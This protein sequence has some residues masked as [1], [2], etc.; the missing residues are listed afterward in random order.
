MQ[1]RDFVIGRFAREALALAAGA[2][3]TACM[4]SSESQP[5]PG[6]LGQACEPTQAC[7]LMAVPTDSRW[8]SSPEASG[9]MGSPRFEVQADDVHVTCRASLPVP[10][11]TDSRE[12]PPI[13]S[14]ICDPMGVVQIVRERLCPSRQDSDPLGLPDTVTARQTP[15]PGTPASAPVPPPRIPTRH[16]RVPDDPV[17]PQAPP[18]EGGDRRDLEWEASG[19]HRVRPAF[20]ENTAQRPGLSPHL[21]RRARAASPWV[22]SAWMRRWRRATSYT[23][24]NSTTVAS[25][26]K[27]RTLLDTFERRGAVVFEIERGSGLE[28]DGLRTASA[29]AGCVREPRNDA[30]C[31]C[32]CL[33]RTIDVYGLGEV[34]R[35][36]PHNLES[37]PTV[38]YPR[39]PFN[40]VEYITRYSILAG[41]GMMVLLAG[42]SRQCAGGI[43]ARSWGRL[44]RRW[45]EFS[46][47]TE[48]DELGEVDFRS[49]LLAGRQPRLRVQPVLGDFAVTSPSLAPRAGPPPTGSHRSPEASSIVSS[50]TQTS[51]SGTAF[52]GGVKPY[53]FVGG[54]AITVD[55]DT[56]PDV[57]TFTK[58]AG[59]FGVGVSYEIPRSNVRLYIEGAG[60]VY[61]WDRYGFDKF[62]STRPWGGGISYRF[63]S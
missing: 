29:R 25:V 47:L 13:S 51:R 54:G 8:R 14:V 59:K 7:T 21:P 22:S 44:L 49:R 55:A 58:G 1:H 17:R 40:G 19:T 28:F 37:L 52:S 30:R 33:K 27:L 46:P 63:G 26:E 61:K 10:P 24:V 45:R 9:P 12:T 18:A 34:R 6:R 2:C 62:S 3:L 57:D 32:V 42:A 39:G 41:A 56:T 23:S 11:C 38:V 5:A 4:A 20:R 16:P 31:I 53:L 36:R 15:G 48:L 35:A 60:W 50:M 43:G